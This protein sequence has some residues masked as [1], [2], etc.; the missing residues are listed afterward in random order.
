ML[1]HTRTGA[2]GPARDSAVLPWI[3][4]IHAGCLV[5]Q[6]VGD[7][8]GFMVE[9]QS[10]AVCQTYVEDVLRPMALSGYRRGRWPIGQYTDDTQLAR[11]LARSLVE[12]QGFSGP[13]YARRIAS[14]FTESRIVGRGMATEA[15]AARLS[16]GVPWN[17]AG[18]PPPAAGNGSAM[19]AA[20]VGLVYAKRPADLIR[21]VAEQG[22][23]THA[24][25][26]CHGG[27]IAIAGAVALATNPGPFLKQGFC[28]QLSNWVR[29]FHPVLA[30]A[31]AEMYKMALDRP[32][33][34]ALAWVRQVE[35]GEGNNDWPGISPF[36]TPS[37]LW[38]IYCFLA[39]G[40]FWDSV[41][42]A[43]SAG[44]DTDT[45]AAMTGAIAG[46]RHGL[47]GIPGEARRLITDQGTWNDGD[48]ER[49]G[50]QLAVLSNSMH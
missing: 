11:E 42:L 40:S 10:T 12:C 25:P 47:S 46:A 6:A 50:G 45:T 35:E 29:P 26:R 15:A 21:I 37:V 44:G 3:V 8:M 14:L 27:A 17:R 2:P 34:A 48:L 49:L 31:L 36:V 33:E 24:D 28:G 39:G 13:D 1:G 16:A 18:T 20:P 9:G 22:M 4:D 7:A 19:R 32:H 43:I 23:I 38:S 41:C 5:G 30:D